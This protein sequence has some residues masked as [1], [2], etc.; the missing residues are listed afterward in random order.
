[1]IKI[2]LCDDDIFDRSRLSSLL[3]AILDGESVKY[4]CTQFQNGLELAAAL[5]NGAGFD[6]YFLDILMRGYDGISLGTEIRTYDKKAKIVYITSSPSF[7]LDS[8]A[9]KAYDYLLKPINEDVLKRTLRDILDQIIGDDCQT[10]ILKTTIGLQKIPLASLVFVE[11]MGRT[12]VY[13]TVSGRD[14]KCCCK[15][16]QASEEL[17]GR[18]FF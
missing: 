3:T 17:L 15:F 9:V 14:F 2:A 8:Y 16:S 11:A 7:A 12:A 18:E 6:L 1:M 13:H 4:S 10:L 5:E